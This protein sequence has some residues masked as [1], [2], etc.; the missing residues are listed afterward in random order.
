MKYLKYFESWGHSF[1]EMS[2]IIEEYL[3]EFDEEHS[4]ELSGNDLWTGKKVN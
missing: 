4:G 1:D 2:E 3:M